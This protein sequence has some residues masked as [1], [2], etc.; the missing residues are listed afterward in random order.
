MIAP[1]SAIDDGIVIEEVYDPLGARV[2]VAEVGA[3]KEGIDLRRIDEIAGKQPVGSA[4]QDGNR[5]R[6]VTRHADQCQLPISQIDVG[7]WRDPASDSH[8]L[9]LEAFRKPEKL[10]EP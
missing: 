2:V 9:R 4:V 7:P 3:R 1:M 10:I 5:V 8:V 6:S